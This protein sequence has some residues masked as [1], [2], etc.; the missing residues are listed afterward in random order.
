MNFDQA[1][2]LA[3]EYIQELQKQDP[4]DELWGAGEQFSNPTD[5]RLAT[6]PGNKDKA[7]Y[8]AALAE[9]IV[10]IR[11]GQ[12][13]PLEFRAFAIDVLQAKHKRPKESR[14]SEAERDFIL[15]RTV[16]YLKSEHGMGKYSSIGP[17]KPDAA[18]VVAEVLGMKHTAVIK[19]YQ[20]QNRLRG[21]K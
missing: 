4:I 12:P 17:C 21:N 18:K 13:I 11:F 3:A 5:G 10:C 2:K 1:V 20:K 14:P 9:I 16:E 6:M 19:A 15:W 8:D 7:A